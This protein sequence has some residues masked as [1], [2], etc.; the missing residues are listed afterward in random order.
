ML[1]EPTESNPSPGRQTVACL[2]EAIEGGKSA[3]IAQVIRVIEE[4]TNKVD[5]VSVEQLAEL[6]SQDL[7]TVARII[8]VANTIGFNPMG[9]EVTS[10]VQAIS[11]ANTWM[12]DASGDTSWLYGYDAWNAPLDRPAD[13]P[14]AKAA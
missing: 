12:K 3:S 11:S 10:V 9:T 14:A 5:T 8:S 13:N 6:I 4:I 2:K 7:A 1:S